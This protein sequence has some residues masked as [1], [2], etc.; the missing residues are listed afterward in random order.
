MQKS[1]VANIN[2]LRTLSWD[3]SKPQLP[4]FAALAQAVIAAF[5]EEEFAWESGRVCLER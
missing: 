4:E 1:G 2:F 3:F 5:R